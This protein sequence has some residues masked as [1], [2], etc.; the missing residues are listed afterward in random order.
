MWV[1]SE[2]LGRRFRK[3]RQTR[4]TDDWAPV[5]VSGHGH[6]YVDAAANFIE[7][8]LIRVLVAAAALE[9]A[10]RMT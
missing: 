3:R 6:L 10:A 7:V 8:A 4:Q 5:I 2:R 9:L 1:I